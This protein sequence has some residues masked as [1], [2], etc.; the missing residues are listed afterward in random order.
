MRFRGKILVVRLTSYVQHPLPVPEDA[1]RLIFLKFNYT[2]T[3]LQL[4]NVRHYFCSVMCYSALIWTPISL[5]LVK[6]LMCGQNQ[7]HHFPTDKNAYK[8]AF[9]FAFNE[10]WKLKFA[11]NECEF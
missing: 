3:K 11:F 1:D 10:F 9:V 6:W 5:T 8:A 7:L 4:L 2:T